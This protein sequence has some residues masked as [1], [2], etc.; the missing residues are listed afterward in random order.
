MDNITNNEGLLYDPV[1]ITQIKMGTTK[2]GKDYPIGYDQSGTPWRF[3]HG[4]HIEINKGYCIG[5]EWDETHKY[6]NIQKI[7]P[8]ANVWKVEVLRELASK[9]DITRNIT[10]CCS[11]AKDLVASK[12]IGLDKMFEWSDKIYD[13]V[14]NKVEKEYDKVGEGIPS[15]KDINVNPPQKES[16]HDT[17]TSGF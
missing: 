6:K 2:N 3:F 5:Y 11:Y 4:E 13:Y 1:L 17:K 15:P 10:V 9:N 8:L 14:I 7:I 16:P 12:D